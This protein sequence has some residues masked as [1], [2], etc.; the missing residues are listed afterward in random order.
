MSRGSVGTARQGG[1][2]YAL[3]RT[4]VAWALAAFYR[5]RV[6]APAGE[7]EGPV[8][9]L[10][11]HPNAL[12]DPALVC[13]ATRR[14]VTFLAKAPLFRL[15]LLGWLLRALGALPVYRRQDD[16]G[17][18]GRNEE[19]FDAAVAALTARGALMLFPEGK[20]H[21]E[22]GLAELRTGAARIA[23]RAARAGAAVKLVPVGL[24]Y[25]DKGRFRSEAHVEVAPALD[26][27]AFL[28]PEGAGPEA[29][30]E[31]V[32]A[33]TRA[34]ADALRA[35]TLDLEAWADL[36]VLRVSEELYALRQGERVAP[37][38]LRAWARGLSLFRAEQPARA[39][40][41]R[42]ALLGFA[43]R[44]ALVRARPEH[45]AVDYRPGPVLG[46][47]LRNLAVLLVGLPLCAL[48]ALLWGL[49]YLLPRAVAR[50]GRV[51]EDMVATVK[52]LATVVLAP[53]WWTVLTV[54][55][56]RLGGPGWA[57]GVFALAVPLALFSRY[58]L[59]RWSELRRD[60][61]VFLALVHRGRVKARLRA[62]GEALAAELD[63]LV[64]E[65]GPRVQ[66][67]GAVE[68]PARA[69]GPVR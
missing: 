48:G 32:R 16:A 15:P 52:L 42:D 45:L 44:L 14:H 66:P 46:F 60:V 13:I 23:L 9:F 63:A 56:W 22:P 68:P 19:T 21:S 40:R 11:N 57:L 50:S 30:A 59:T 6:E 65:Y 49:P 33:L 34:A 67:A 31:A 41:V 17:Q 43:G 27:A 54:V 58:F 18:T 51:E 37:E 26:A 29:E 61:A 35:V 47:V 28:P 39:E 12:V 3:V 38:R 20:S 36:P 8:L 64:A 53:V 62:Q 55:G 69:A 4:V 25:A 7:P 2:L 24:T 1:A 10:G 5:V